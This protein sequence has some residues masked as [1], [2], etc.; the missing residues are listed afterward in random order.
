M[1]GPV[2]DALLPPAI[3]AVLTIVLLAVGHR[4]WAIA[5]LAALVLL[6][7]ESVPHLLISPLL[8]FKE[9]AEKVPPGA[10]VVLSSGMPEF[11]DTSRT[12]PGMETLKSLRTAAA[13]HRRTGL[14]ILVSGASAPAGDAL[15]GDVADAA[16]VADGMASSLSQD[17]D[18]PVAW[19]ETASTNVWQSAAAVAGLLRGAGIDGIYLVGQP[20]ELRLRVAVFRAAGLRVT[21]EPVPYRRQRTLD[22]TG[23]IAFT[24][25]WLESAVAIREWAGLAC[26]AMPL[27]VA[28]MRGPAVTPG[29]N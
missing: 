8:H 24:P 22:L 13:V 15:A 7:V 18:A 1:T 23:L 11:L 17:F 19:R 27:C 25:A 21:P 14:P 10:I 3:L 28:W 29:P 20:W 6:S 16:P 2:A 5:I 12:V 4:R 9:A 26:Q